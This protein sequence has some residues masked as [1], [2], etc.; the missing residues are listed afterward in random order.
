M[1]FYLSRGSVEDD[2]E[3]FELDHLRS[4]KLGPNEK[5]EDKKKNEITD[6]QSLKFR[7]FST[8]KKYIRSL[9]SKGPQIGLLCRPAIKSGPW[10]SIF[11][12]RFRREFLF[13]QSISVLHDL[14]SERHDL[15]AVKIR[16]MMW[17]PPSRYTSFTLESVSSW[18]KSKTWILNLSALN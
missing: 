17:K 15:S 9:D 8:S 12:V 1:G 18:L 3:S 11:G 10:L 4:I 7:P 14:Y 6:L 13:L 2:L 16:P 5:S